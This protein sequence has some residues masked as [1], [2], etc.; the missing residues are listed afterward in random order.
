M[1]FYATAAQVIPALVLAM[2]FSNSVLTRKPTNYSPHFAE[3]GEDDPGSWNFFQIF[4]RIYLVLLLTAGEIAAL[5]AL[6]AEREHWLSASLVWFGLGA[7]LVGVVAPVLASQWA[8]FKQH[9]AATRP[10]WGWIIGFTL[11]LVFL[12]WWALA[13]GREVFG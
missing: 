4:G 2:V 11:C 8:F 3:E 5:V 9:A 1:E 13:I 12:T 10:E 7:G 6:H